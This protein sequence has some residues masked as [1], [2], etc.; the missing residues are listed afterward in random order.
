MLLGQMGVTKLAMVAITVAIALIQ[1][2]LPPKPEKVS[3]LA[4]AATAAMVNMGTTTAAMGMGKMDQQ[5]R[6]EARTA[7]SFRSDQAECLASRRLFV[8]LSSGSIAV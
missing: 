2:T 4:T 7:M 1:G 5:Q 6:L 8:K 3:I